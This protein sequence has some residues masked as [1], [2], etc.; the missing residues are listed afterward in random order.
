[1]SKFTKT[2]I[3]FFLY[4]YD[5]LEMYLSSCGRSVHTIESYRDTLTLFKRF[6]TTAR[7]LDIRKFTFNDC[8]CDFIF[9]SLTGSKKTETL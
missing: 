1:M 6:V 9:P 8:T 3:F 7:G 2:N 4:S 5:F